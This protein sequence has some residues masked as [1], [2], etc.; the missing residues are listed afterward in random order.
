MI[1]AILIGIALISGFII[2]SMAKKLKK[3]KAN[4]KNLLNAIDK[5][6]EEIEKHRHIIKRMEEIN[7][8][9]SDIKKQIRDNDNP[10]DRANAA[11]DVMQ[12]LSRSGSDR[13]DKSTAKD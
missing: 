8:N 1:I 12:N 7:K 13:K 2:Y 4:N 5:Q 10:V 6:K 9:A 11:T 3:L